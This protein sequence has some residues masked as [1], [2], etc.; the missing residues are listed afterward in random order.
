VAPADDDRALGRHSVSVSGVVRDHR[1]RVLLVKRADNGQWE[2]PGGVM[3]LDEEIHQALIREVE[4]ETGLDVQPDQL[5]GV[6]KNIRLGIVALVFAC[7]PTGGHLRTSDESTEVAWVEPAD[8][9]QLVG[10]R[11]RIRIEDAL[12]DL[13]A[14]AIR[15]HSH[16]A[17]I[18]R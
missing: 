8:L 10:D 16:P 11:I 9:A 17:R 6:Y 15:N 3:G 1:G 5:T 14:P 4:E 13:P 18:A 12:A 2:I 7:R